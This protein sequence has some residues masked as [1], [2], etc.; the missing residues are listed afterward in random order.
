M[1]LASLGR[2]FLRGAALA[3]CVGAV[4]LPSCVADEA[5]KGASRCGDGVRQPEEECDVVAS[6][7]VDD[8]G[9]PLPAKDTGCV[10]CREAP[11]WRCRDN[12]C[13]EHCGDG[14]VVGGEECDPPDGDGCNTSCRLSV[15]KKDP[16]SLAGHWI[17][18]QTD[19]SVA[20]IGT[21]GVQTSSNWF[22]WE[23]AQSGDEWQV[24][25]S[26]FCGIV[27]TGNANVKLSD[28]GIRGLMHKNRQDAKNPRGGRRGVMR[29]QGGGC[30]L[31]S[32]RHYFVRGG[33]DDLLPPSFGAEPELET[34]GPL[35]IANDVYDPSKGGTL[36][37]A[38]D[39][40]GDGLP[41]VPFEVTGLV[42]GTRS[43]V[44]RDWSAYESDETHPIAQFASE[45]VARSDF[46]NQE[47]ILHLKCGSGGM[48]PLLEA[49]ST[50]SLDRPGRVLFRYLGDKLDSPAVRAL[51]VE[52]PGGG[53]DDDDFA[54]CARIRAALPH[55]PA[56]K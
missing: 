39:P 56:S 27:V 37:L 14:K 24:V 44:Q 29:V 1:R 34:L 31:E 19:F 26:L 35:P 55:D 22:Y 52:F 40:D 6:A 30:Y 54:T 41:G 16:C 23:V 53:S 47:R 10:Q 49:G 5:L 46:K 38:D 32:T 45:F 50:P 9:K 28:V 18:R 12:V 3:L 8:D 25:N 7:L 11:G 36:E 21:K 33:K 51:V 15:V 20:N 43:A 4:T 17:L 2:F 42:N 13:K 48:C